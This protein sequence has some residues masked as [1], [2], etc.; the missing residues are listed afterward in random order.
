[1]KV[2]EVRLKKGKG[3][4]SRKLST[5]E[6]RPH[7]IMERGKSSKKKKPT[8]RLNVNCKEEAKK[9]KYETRTE[10]SPI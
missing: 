8:Y 7:T 6:N 2:G 1:M 10:F 5:C 9:T 3:W 4:R